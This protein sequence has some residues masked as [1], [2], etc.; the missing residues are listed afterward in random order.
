MKFSFT[1]LSTLYCDMKEIIT[2]KVYHCLSSSQNGLKVVSTS[3]PYMAYF[4]G[5]S[6]GSNKKKLSTL[7]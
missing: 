3:A 6:N 2:T 7:P 1:K 5:N 4:N